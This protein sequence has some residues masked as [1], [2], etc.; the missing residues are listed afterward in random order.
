MTRKWLC[1]LGILVCGARA[2]VPLRWLGARLKNASSI[3]FLNFD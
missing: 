2:E 3:A 1:A